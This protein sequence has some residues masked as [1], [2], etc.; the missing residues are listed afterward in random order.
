[1]NVS[2]TR[3]KQ[4]IK[5]DIER[6]QKQKILSLLGGTDPD[7]YDSRRD[8]NHIIQGLDL[9]KALGAEQELGKNND[10]ANVNFSNMDFSGRDLSNFNF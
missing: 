1:M 3:L 7:G 2:K 4:I 5:E 10:L 6:E 8:P 9:M